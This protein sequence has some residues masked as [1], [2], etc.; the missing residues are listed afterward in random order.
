MVL[1]A[2]HETTTH[3]ITNGTFLLLKD[4][5]QRALFD[6]GT[7]DQVAVGVEELLR[8]ESPIQRLTRVATEDFQMHGQQIKKGQKVFLMIG[9]ANRDSAQFAEGEKLDL[10]RK[11]NRHLAFGFGGHYCLGA[12]LGRLEGQI[13]LTTLFRRFPGLRLQ[14]DAPERL[15]NVAFR[16]FKSVPMSLG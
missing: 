4:P 15:E 7:P 9:A 14:D 11:D 5:A 1:F 13:A 6:S 3:L 16:G 8:Y 2:G 12:A 10:Q